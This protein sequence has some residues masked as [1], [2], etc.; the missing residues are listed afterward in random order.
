MRTP[1]YEQHDTDANGN[2]S[3]GVTIGRGFTIAWQNGPLA[4]DG[5]RREPTGAFVEDIVAAAIG[6]MEHYQASRFACAEN[7]DAL[8]Y[9]KAAAA[10]LDARTKN[11]QT[12]GVEGTHAA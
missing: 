3:G 2:P 5:V 8:D 1:I 6:R 7:Q 10:R 12:R 11:R 4:V 9:L